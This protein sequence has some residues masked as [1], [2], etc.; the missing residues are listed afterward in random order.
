MGGIVTLLVAHA[1]PSTLGTW[2]WWGWALAAIALS[3]AGLYLAAGPIVHRA[4]TQAPDVSTLDAADG[5][6][7]IGDQCRRTGHYYR[8]NETRTVYLCQNVGCDDVRLRNVEPYDREA[9]A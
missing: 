8:L 5:V 7:R 6:G 2:P 4:P 1:D 9:S 3:V